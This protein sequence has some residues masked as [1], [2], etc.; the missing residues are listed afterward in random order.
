MI[1][2]NTRTKYEAQCR[3]WEAECKKIKQYNQE[4]DEIINAEHLYMFLYVAETNTSNIHGVYLGENTYTIDLRKALPS[5][6]L[7]PCSQH[8]WI[9]RGKECSYDFNSKIACVLQISVSLVKEMLGNG[10]LLSQE[11]FFPNEK[12]D[13]GYRILLMRQESSRLESDN[14]KILP[15]NMITDFE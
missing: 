1:K 8:G 15:E 3:S 14:P 4:I 11:N 6:F 10:A 12:I 9:V 13:Q 5:T 7:R 2:R